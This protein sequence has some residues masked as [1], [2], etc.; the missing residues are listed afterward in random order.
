MQGKQRKQLCPWITNSK[1][2]IVI[3]T[4]DGS[5]SYN[6]LSLYKNTSMFFSLGRNQFDFFFLPLRNTE[7]NFLNKCMARLEIKYDKNICSL[8]NK[9]LITFIYDK[10]LHM[11]NKQ[12]LTVFSYIS[13]NI[14]LLLKILWLSKID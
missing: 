13:L 8:K 5:L 12:L 4:F 2:L 10:I 14:Y 1:I 6:C 7:N 3:Y 11:K 9:V